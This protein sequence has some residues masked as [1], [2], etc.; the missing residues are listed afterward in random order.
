[1]KILIIYPY[2]PINEEPITGGQLYDHF[3][4]SRVIT[5]GR[6]YTIDFLTDDMLCMSNKKFFNFAYLHKFSIAKQYDI[7]L[8]NS[9]LYTHLIL[10]S[11]FLKIFSKTKLIS[12]HHHFDF[13]AEI[14]TFKRKIRKFAEIFFLRVSHATIIPNPYIKEIFHQLLPNRKVIFIE[15]AIKRFSHDISQNKN[16]NIN[17]LFVGTVE[18]R[19][20]LSYLVKSLDLLGKHNIL[21]HC[22]IVGKI[23]DEKYFTMLKQE[24][25]KLD[26]EV[27]ITFRGRV[28]DD[29]L[30][31][32]YSN[33][34]CF[35]F[36]SLQEG[37]GY[38][39]IEAMAFGLPVIA[40]NNSAMPFTVKNGI[41]GMLAKNKDFEDFERCIVEIIK[42]NQLREL[43]SKGA[44][45]T[46][47][48]SRTFEDIDDNVRLLCQSD[49]EILSS[50]SNNSR[51]F[52]KSTF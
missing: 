26:L 50:S 1:M 43:L 34:T 2:N 31:E 11:L 30:I 9:R 20:G 39:I 47:E 40:F 44:L 23:V 29:E 4:I 10:L 41:N 5:H 17:L 33:A 36:P 52:W 32:Y 14:N 24:I 45:E 12:I 46:Y 37:Y 49:F 27:S 3:F 13:L 18:P 35:V 38:V 51:K 6:N 8:T 48:R 19:K 15:S 21:F 22:D 28:N 25:K 42:N 16:N 7:V